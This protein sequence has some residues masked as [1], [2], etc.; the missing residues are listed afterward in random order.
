MRSSNLHASTRHF[1]KETYQ[2]SSTAYAAFPTMLLYCWTGH[3]YDGGTAAVKLA[4]ADPKAHARHRPY[5]A[6]LASLTRST[7]L[8]SGSPKAEPGKARKK[9]WSYRPT[10]AVPVESSQ[11][12]CNKVMLPY[13]YHPRDSREP[14]GPARGK[15][16]SSSHAMPC[17]EPMTQ[18][19]AAHRQA[20]A[21][22]L[23]PSRPPPLVNTEHNTPPTT[24]PSKK[25]AAGRGRGRG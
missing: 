21:L 14:A 18:S 9:Y 22:S 20:A 1:A 19:S 12:S 3:A 8:S 4:V 17:H 7:P 15:A 25:R 11:S 16:S 6:A 23:P 2:Q 13:H 10:M 5:P 24:P